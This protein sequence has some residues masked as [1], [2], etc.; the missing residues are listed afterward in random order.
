MTW[1]TSRTY[2]Q[3]TELFLTRLPES[4][5]GT[6]PPFVNISQ[7]R[8]E[9]ILDERIAAQPLI[10]VRWGH[11]VTGITP[12][13]VVTCAQGTFTAEYVIVC[14]GGRADDI[15]THLGVSFE[16]RTFD[17]RFLICD[18]AATL[19]GWELERRFYF[20][21]PWNPGRQVLIHPCPGGVYRIDWQ[22]PSDFDLAA[23]EADGRLDRRIRAIIGAERPYETVWR[24]VYRFSSRIADR[25]VV[26]RVL[27]A[28]DAAHQYAPF[29]ARGLNSGVADVENA[30]WKVA[31]ALNG[32][33]GSDLVGTYHDERHA[34]AVENLAVT[35]A[36]MSF[37]VPQNDSERARRHAALTGGR[38]SEVDSG[39][40]AEP[41][42]YADSPLTTASELDAGRPRPSRP[43]RGELPVPAPGTLVPDVRTARGRL[44]ELARTGFLLVTDRDDVCAE[45]PLVRVLATTSE[46]A[47]ALGAHPGETWVVRPDAYV[48]AVVPA[49]ADVNTALR[50]A[51]GYSLPRTIVGSK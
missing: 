30:A 38:I 13:G 44:R 17:D 16:G 41:F 28:G 4:P 27:L 14:A 8:T 11:E 23:E 48:A 15:R 19:P 1:R 3:D 37:L 47:E 33:G 49:G 24:S 5:A 10:E 50:R 42:W 45:S 43:P 21:P 7:S 51:C 39:R 18:I 31:Y 40:F 26:G 36:T 25:M 22:V 46:L 32:R 2:Y 6:F 29:G 12:D 34:A 9:R 35:S 20:D